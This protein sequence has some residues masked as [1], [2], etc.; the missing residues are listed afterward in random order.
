MYTLHQ[1]GGEG[2]DLDFSSGAGPHAWVPPPVRCPAADLSDGKREVPY[3]PRWCFLA[4]PKH[5]NKKTRTRSRRT[6]GFF[7]LSSLSNGNR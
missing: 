3:S 1:W 7:V 6:I 5:T 4:R 2:V